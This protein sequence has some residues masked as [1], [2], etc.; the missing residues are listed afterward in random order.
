M[1][2]LLLSHNLKAESCFD[3]WKCLELRARKTASQWLWENPKKGGGEISLY[4]SLQQRKQAVWTS[5]IRYQVK[6][7][8]ILCLG[9]C[10]PLGPLNS[11]LSYAS[12]VSLI[13]LLLAFP[14]LLSNLHL[15]VACA[16]IPILGALVHIW[17]QKPLM[18][19]TFLVYWY[20]RRCFH[21]TVPYCQKLS[22]DQR[23]SRVIWAESKG[24]IHL[25]SF[26]FVSLRR[27]WRAL[28]IGPPPAVHNLW[29]TSPLN[30]LVLAL[31][32]CSSG[33]A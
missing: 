27:G 30:S 22:V 20:G 17:R 1:L 10:K 31:N 9:R 21:F 33:P 11:F 3:W 19:V 18:V 24:L 14:Q 25:E 8:S 12:P 2:L 4:T 13:T 29:E 23:K 15:E 5:R 32:L 26:Q 6:E 7:F 28:F 16:L